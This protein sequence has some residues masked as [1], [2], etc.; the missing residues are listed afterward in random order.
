MFHRDGT[1]SLQPNVWTPDIVTRKDIIF[2]A[3]KNGSYDGKP[4]NMNADVWQLVSIFI[5]NVSCFVKLSS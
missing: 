4:Y 3:V 1:N 2:E 5:S